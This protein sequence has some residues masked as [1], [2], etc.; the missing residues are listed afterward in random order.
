MTKPPR[1]TKPTAGLNPWGARSFKQGAL[2]FFIIKLALIATII[3]QRNYSMRIK[4]SDV[5]KVDAEDA[6]L[7]N[8][9]IRQCFADVASRFGL[10]PENCPTH[11]SNSTI[12][13]VKEQMAKGV[14]FFVKID[15]GIP[16]GCVGLEKAGE[17]ICYVTRLGV[18]PG[19]RKRGFGEELLEKA[20]S[21]AREMSAKTVSAAIM[22][23]DVE[24]K[25]WYEN[26]GFTQTETRHFDHLPFRVAFLNLSLR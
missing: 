3:D 14:E 15:C 24:L 23:Q 7:L 26:R 20:V 17:D 10:T 19:R 1:N 4:R 2:P 11:P 21:E 16:A 9:V 25:K 22:D 8:F 18:L 6:S 12:E 13:K 5:K